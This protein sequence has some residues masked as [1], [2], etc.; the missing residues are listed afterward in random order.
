[1]LENGKRLQGM[2]DF[3]QET[4]RIAQKGAS[5]EAQAESLARGAKPTPEQL[6]T[7]DAEL[8]RIQKQMA[9]LQKALESL[10]KAGPQEAADQNAME[11]PVGEARDAAEQLAQALARGD[12]EKAAQLA[13]KL[14]EALAKIQQTVG[15]AAASSAASGGMSPQQQQKAEAA[16]RQ[17]S[18]LVEDQTRVVERTQKLED[19]KVARRIEEQKKALR[20]LARRQAVAVSSAAAQRDFPVDALAQMRA[21][22]NEFEAG[23]VQSAPS[24]LRQAAQRAQATRHEGIAEQERDLA[25][26]LE[27]AAGQASQGPAGPEAEQVGRDQ[28]AVKAKAAE[29]QGQLR[30]L[31]NETGASAEDALDALSGAQGEQ[32]SAADALGKRDSAAALPHAQ[33]ALELLTQGANQ[34]GQSAAGAQQRRQALIQPFQRPSGAVRLRG[35]GGQSGA[36]L[37]F[38]P[39]PSEREY[40]PPK[41]LREELER[42]L[43][44]NRPASQDALIKEYFKRIAQ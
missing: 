22:Q 4:G 13:R 20:D 39:L 2:Q 30:R 21:V 32:G 7:L 17:W 34:M 5:I 42:S 10:P 24:L 29:L 37:G 25:D 28:A 26:E 3:Y 16:Q 41:E 9:E 1:M 40:L 44:E 12:Y 8:G 11:M 36:Q 6:K 35:G 27:G 38:V 33:K 14:S 18:Q 23:R 19:A 15:R 31:E 43:K